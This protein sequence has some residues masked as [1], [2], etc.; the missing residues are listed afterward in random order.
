MLLLCAALNPALAQKTPRVAPEFAVHMADGKDLRLSQY[1]GKVVILAF[2]N[3]G[4]SHC[5][6]FAKQLSVYQQEYGPKGVQVLAVV[7]DQG[8]KAGLEKFRAAYV[9][10][11]PLGYSDEAAVMQWLQQPVEQGYFVPI[12]AFVDRKGVVQSQ[13][14]GD[15]NL[16][17]D[18]DGNIRHKLDAMLRS[19]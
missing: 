17:Q 4:C 18:P 6:G 11:Y 13:H 3:T 5:Q 1:R 10:G 7:F 8:A 15:D 9:K 12:V 2:L 14:L 16:F 19:K